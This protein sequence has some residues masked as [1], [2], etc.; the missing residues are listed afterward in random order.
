MHIITAVVTSGFRPHVRSDGQG[1]LPGVT[2]SH[3]LAG[4]TGAHGQSPPWLAGSPGQGGPPPRLHLPPTEPHTAGCTPP[5][6]V[7]P[8][9]QWLSPTP[10]QGPGDGRLLGDGESDHRTGFYR[11]F[12]TQDSPLS[13]S[14]TSLSLS[15]RQPTLAES[16][17]PGGAWATQHHL[18]WCPSSH[19]GPWPRPSLPPGPTWRA[20]VRRGRELS[21]HQDNTPAPAFSTSAGWRAALATAPSFS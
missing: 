14:Q 11:G 1:S 7:C 15:G 18:E 20:G 5:G 19:G 4:N 8:K 6:H 17:R 3:H 12:G 9:G 13:P 2:L 16:I 10:A 21:G